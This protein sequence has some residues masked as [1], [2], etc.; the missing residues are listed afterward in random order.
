MISSLM[1]MQ[2]TLDSQMEESAVE[3]LVLANE[4]QDLDEGD[5]EECEEEGEEE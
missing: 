3:G 4:S 5:D 2:H 1:K